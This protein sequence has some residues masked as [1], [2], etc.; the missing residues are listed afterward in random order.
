MSECP[1]KAYKVVLVGET[2]VGKS[3][4]IC[5][6]VH[7]NFINNFVTTMSGT[8]SSKTVNFEEIKSSICLAMWDTAGQEKYLFLTKMFYK[9]QMLQL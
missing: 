7:N 6:Y 9:M 1:D 2:A 3:C 5:R 8:F 4:L